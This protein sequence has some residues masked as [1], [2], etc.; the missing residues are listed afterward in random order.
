MFPFYQVATFIL[1]VR[2]ISTKEHDFVT[3]SAIATASIALVLLHLALWVCVRALGQLLTQGR[4]GPERYEMCVRI[5]KSPECRN[6][7]Y[8]TYEADCRSGPYTRSRMENLR[9]IFGWTGSWYW[10]PVSLFLEPPVGQFIRAENDEGGDRKFWTPE[11]YRLQATLAEDAVVPS[12][13]L[14]ANYLPPPMNS[15]IQRRLLNR[16]SEVTEPRRCLI[17]LH[18]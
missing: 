3:T 5:R 18:S 15:G 8:K 2:A 6:T 11:I 14:S 4:M 9:A 17:E 1:A 7:E 16:V 10:T 13:T 12:S